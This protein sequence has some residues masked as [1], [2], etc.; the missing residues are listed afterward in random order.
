MADEKYGLLVQGLPQSEEDAFWE[1]V[2]GF[3]A[4]KP[5]EPY[6]S[7]GARV[8]IDENGEGVLTIDESLP[9][10]VWLVTKGGK[11]VRLE[12]VQGPVKVRE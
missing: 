7:P 10:G 9:D 5:S 12:G 6:Y 3:G 1:W 11:T 8:V 4:E 2:K